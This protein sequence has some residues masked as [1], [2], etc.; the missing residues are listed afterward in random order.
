MDSSV[1]VDM[2]VRDGYKKPTDLVIDVCIAL[3]FYGTGEIKDL[4]IFL[5][6]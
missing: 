5:Y 6:E 1:Q 4:E 2:R 3:Q